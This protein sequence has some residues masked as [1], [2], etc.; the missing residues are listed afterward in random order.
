M[1]T[2]QRPSPRGTPPAG[3]QADEALTHVAEYDKVDCASR[4]MLRQLLDKGATANFSFTR[5]IVVLEANTGS[6]HMYKLLSAAASRAELSA[7]TA[8]RA[9]KDILYNKWLQDGCEELVDTQKT[10]SLIDLY[11][12]FL[13]LERRHVRA[14]LEAHLRVRRDRGIKAGEFTDLTWDA[15]ALDFLVD[16]VEFEDVHA[17]EGAKEAP[18]VLS[19]HVSRA[20]RRQRDSGCNAA[21]VPALHLRHRGGNL[22][23]GD[24]NGERLGSCAAGV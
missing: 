19:R 1:A 2:R 23:A 7:E 9:L 3:F 12:P 16:R 15:D 17:I 4:G 18:V 11:V 24:V 13:P 21:P 14:V 22:L 10:L 8:Q 5:S 20:L 6:A